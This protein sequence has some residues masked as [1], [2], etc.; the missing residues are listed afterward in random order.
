MCGASRERQVTIGEGFL[1]DAEGAGA[2]GAS[3]NQIH[4]LVKHHC[5]C[6]KQQSLADAT[7]F[8]EI[9]VGV[10]RQN[11]EGFFATGKAVAEKKDVLTRLV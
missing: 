9:V 7:L 2:G 4:F 6:G 11:C 5:T 8:G 10:Q 3:P 1:N